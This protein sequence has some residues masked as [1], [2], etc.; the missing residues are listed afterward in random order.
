MEVQTAD[1]ID[2][3]LYSRQLYVLGHEAMRRMG[4]SNVL[5]SGMRG[6]GAEIA[7]DVVLAGVKSVTIHD[8]DKVTLSDLSSQFFLR[9]EDVGKNRADA[10]LPRLAEL[11]AYVPVH[12]HAGPLT[13]SFLNT[14]EVVVL[15]FNSLEEQ[16]RIN[17]IT[18]K[19]GIRFI[20]AQTFGLFGQIFNDFGK[21]FTV[22]DT[23][24]EQ[25]VSFLIENI[26]QE[27]K[28]IVTCHEETRHGLE[29]GDHVTFS[30]VEG[31]H[32]LNGC[33]PKRVKV[34]SP[35]SF[36][37]DCDTSRFHPYTGRGTVTQVKMPKN[38]TFKSLPESLAD[39]DFFMTDF[40]KFERP[41]QLHLG[42]QALHTFK[43]KHGRLPR[44]RNDEDAKELIA[45]VHALNAQT[46]NKVDT[47][48]EKLLA[49]LS[50]NA[51][52]DL[53][54]VNAV[55]GA[56][57]A[58]EVLK[59]C[60]GKFHPLQQWMYF[61]SLESL[62]EEDTITEADV[63]PIGSRHDAQIAVFGRQFQERMENQ[64]WFLV[65][66]GAIGCEIL[67]IWA[68]TGVG[69]GPNGH[70]Y[71]TDMDTIEKSNL[72][73]Q[74]LFRPWDVS[75][76]KSEVAA[77]AARHMNPRINITS[78]QN[79]V[80]AETE[81]TYND[82]FFESL[83]GVAN[84]LDNVDAR[85][86]MDR[87]CVY[88][89]KPLLESGTQGTKGNT[90]VVIPFLTESYSSSQ[91][92]PEKSIPICTLKNF[93]NQIAHTLQWARDMFE[94]M[95][96]Q[97]AEN[98][99]QYLSNPQF[100]DM[101]KKQ[102]A[103]AIEIFEG[104]RD[105]LTV[106]RPISF[107]ECITWARLRFE[108]LFRNQIL[109][110][111]HVF[112][113]DQVTSTGQPFWSGPKRCPTPL[114]FDPNDPLHMDFVI[115]SANL[116][117]VN[118]GLNGHT[119]RAVFAKVIE[120]MMIPEFVPKSGVKIQVN[121]NEAAQN[122]AAQ[123]DAGKV[124]TILAELPAPSSLAGYRLNPI[125]FEKDDDTN[126]HMDF[127]TACSNLRA[128]NYK[129]PHADKHQSKLIAGKI[130]PAIATTTALVVGLVGLEQYKLING[131]KKLESFKNGFVNLALPFFGFSEPIKSATMKYNDVEWGL[132]D[133]FD[134]KGDITLQ[135]FIDYF[136]REHNLE[137][138][139]ISCGVSMLYSF[140]MQAAKRKERLGMKMTEV[141]ESVTKKQIPAHTNS[142]VFEICVNDSTGED[143]EVPYVRYVFR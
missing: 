98:V 48:D 124:E 36:A 78:H 8:D 51:V 137:I 28:A 39:P 47:F 86:Y 104:V 141:V 25:P 9:E 55:V 30:E 132:W 114:E 15:T 53:A 79:R 96:K 88:Y 27:H 128:S 6:L 80:G 89:R 108:D 136:Q 50:Y 131:N 56:T 111:L 32:E 65:G 84:A 122:N 33:E 130:I 138:T 37:I 94:G 99:N 31:M 3:A 91:D 62:P 72:N 109:Q 101:I 16:L 129:I 49:Y 44:P 85:M 119:D 134:V 23:N 71:V 67:K 82:D 4:R 95:Y 60:T 29:D 41:A 102:S 113:P 90:Q 92:P 125:D 115:A 140:F 22:Y 112:P 103:Q 116:H 13:E 52:G 142:L 43:G 97:G 106:H 83:S 93:P 126:F 35:Y 18:R 34:I 70:V 19:L 7:K 20:V 24:G 40:G 135:E 61:D 26:T 81:S 75:K 10:T 120:N 139:M 11:N 66:S 117:A 1:N 69:S 74:F 107:E 54:P 38:I 14:F 100:V 42:F 118:Y 5:I 121:E 127:I 123:P 110:L 17:E 46:G 58:Q 21:E 12:K 87:R 73:R 68:M 133:R 64:R 2:E 57:C 63:Q 105:S 59:A 143:V 76:A 45:L 77:T